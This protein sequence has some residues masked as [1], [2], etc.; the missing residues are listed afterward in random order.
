M[1]RKLQLS[2]GEIVVVGI[3]GGLGMLALACGFINPLWFLGFIACVAVLLAVI[4][5][6]LG[7]R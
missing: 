1:R 7:R 4:I 3:S 5:P 2:A 6:K